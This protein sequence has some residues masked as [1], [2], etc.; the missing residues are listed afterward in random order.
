MKPNLLLAA[1]VILFGVGSVQPKNALQDNGCYIRLYEINKGFGTIYQDGLGGSH[2]TLGI[3]GHRRKLVDRYEVQSLEVEG[4]E[5]TCC[6]TVFRFPGRK[7]ARADV[8]GNEE[9][10]NVRETGLVAIKSF[11]KRSEDYCRKKFIEEE[12]EMIE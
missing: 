1:L 10:D 2:P 6:F 4:D 3:D 9:Y 11:I 7:G 8:R 12:E 5:V